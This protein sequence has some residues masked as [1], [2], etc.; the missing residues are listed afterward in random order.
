VQSAKNQKTSRKRHI[1]ILQV[2]E[3][4]SYKNLQALERVGEPEEI[5]DLVAF[6]ASDH[7]AYIT[8]AN[9]VCDGGASVKG[10][11]VNMSTA[12]AASH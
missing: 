11:V 10:H 4:E 1:R 12:A 8:G 5:A 6:L 7:A 9:I 2:Y 3:S